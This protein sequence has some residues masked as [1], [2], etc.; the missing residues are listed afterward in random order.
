MVHT[1]IIF[2]YFFAS[3]TFVFFWIL[4]FYIVKCRC[5]KFIS[6]AL[7]TLSSVCS[8]NCHAFIMTLKSWKRS[9][10]RMTWHIC[11]YIHVYAHKCICLHIL[12][13]WSFEYF[14][15][16]WNFSEH[17][18]WHVVWPLVNF[19]SE[20]LWKFMLKYRNCISIYR[21]VYKIL[22]EIYLKIERPKNDWNFLEESSE[23]SKQYHKS[24]VGRMVAE[25]IW[26]TGMSNNSPKWIQ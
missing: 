22:C 23:L 13:S 15:W 8:T 11:L 3:L 25:A 9:F 7:L 6:S 17:N 24:K 14:P 4:N 12:L 20:C 21:Q 2:V 19:K 10:T 5:S 16:H 18:L 26:K 1:N